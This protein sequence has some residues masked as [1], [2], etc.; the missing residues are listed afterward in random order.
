MIT[1]DNVIKDNIKEHNPNQPR[2]PD[3]PY[4]I[5]INGGS[6]S[7]KINSLFNL[8]SQQPDIDKIYLYAKGPYEAKYQFLINK[9]E[10]TSLAHINDIKAFIEYL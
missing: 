6:E 4:R 3:H 7:G 1:F 5:L 8:I 2:I 9:R 10:G